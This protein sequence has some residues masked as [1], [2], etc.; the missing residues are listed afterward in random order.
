MLDQVMAY[1]QLDKPYKLYTDACDYAIGGILC[2]EDDHGIERP[3]QYISKQLS[4]A[5]LRWATIEKEAYAVVYALDKLRPYLYASEFTIFTDHKPLKSLFLSEIKNTKIQ[6][7]AVLI[8][9]YGAPIQYR[10]GKN[11]IRADMLSRI[12]TQ[13]S[14]EDP[15]H[16]SAIKKYVLW[17][18]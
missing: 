11:N 12:K 2:Q 6:R 14:A 16:L 3:I 8:A 9:E 13:V 5:A 1:P 15:S 4:G 10:K 17:K 18:R 7:W